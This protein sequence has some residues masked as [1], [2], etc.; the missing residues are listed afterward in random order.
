M[1]D[2][3]CQLDAYNEFVEFI[4]SI[5]TL[6]AMLQ[7]RLSDHTEARVA[8]LLEKN[9]QDLISPDESQ[10]LDEYIRLEHIMRQIK[11]RAFEKLDCLEHY[12]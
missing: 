5:P 2:G 6:E 4:T 7:Y 10:E 11:I 1:N 12:P 8:E 3:D 9:R